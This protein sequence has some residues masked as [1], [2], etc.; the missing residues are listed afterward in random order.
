MLSRGS[1]IGAFNLESNRPRAYRDRDL[2]LLEAFAG[3]A[4]TTLERAHL[5]EERREKQEIEKELRV[6][7]TVQTFFS[8][9]K[10]RA[11]GHFRI[12][13]ENHPSLE[14][15]GDYYDFY[16]VGTS[17]LAFAIADVA[18][19]GVPAALIMSGFRATLHTL[20]SQVVTAGQ[21]V[22][23]AN[24]ILLET[25][26][27]RDFVTAFIGVLNT[28][29]GELTYCNAGH[30]PPVLMKPDGT[31][32]LL[33][34]GGPILGVF[35]EYP[36]TE[37]RLLLTDETL[38]CYTDGATEARNKN[39]EEYGEARLIQS[40]KDSVELSP[41]RLCHSLYQPLKAFYGDVGRADDI[42]YLVLKPR[43]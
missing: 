17:H 5:Y 38:L 13:G 36:M 27:R 21:I 6:A 33:E 37:G 8:P 7:R 32:R 42:T 10:S 2:Q 31:Y 35:E 24:E 3:L 25:V 16:P 23:R 19:K 29:T 40:L 12:A 34:C 15:S 9:K 14:V 43:K 18:G 30:N 20:A 11:A 22:K 41:S 39:D 26:R 28:E 4:A 1:V